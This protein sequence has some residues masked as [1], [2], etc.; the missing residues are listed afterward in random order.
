[1]HK[2]QNPI[3]K[4]IYK[5]YVE[6]RKESLQSDINQLNLEI[7]KLDNDLQN[8]NSKIAAV[9][10]DDIKKQFHHLIKIVPQSGN[11]IYFKD[12]KN[13]SDLIKDGLW[14]GKTEINSDSIKKMRILVQDLKPCSVGETGLDFFRNLSTLEEQIFAFEEQ[15]KLSI[16][17]NKPLFL[18][19]RDAHDEFIKI[20]MKYKNDINKAVVHCFT[21]TQKQLDSYLNLGFYIGLTGWIC[22]ERRNVELRKS[23][24]NIPLDKLMIE[25]DS[26]YLIP[27]NLDIKP[28]NNR[29]EPSYLPHIAKEIADIINIDSSKLIDITYKNSISFFS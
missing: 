4:E 21:G 16:E 3:M 1:M 23:I 8:T 10:I 11:I 17:F 27:R 22:D 9:G 2:V 15:I 24:K 28:E 12:D 6:D 5:I 19:Q 7:K 26:P 25:T 14:C 29:N 18:H 13:S 20:I